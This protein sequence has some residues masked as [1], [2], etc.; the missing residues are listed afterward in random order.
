[1]D[2]TLGYFHLYHTLAYD[3]HI[4]G[5]GALADD[6]VAEAVNDFSPQGGDLFHLFGGEPQEQFTVLK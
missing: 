2:S 6:G 1:V 5:G 3:V 4:V